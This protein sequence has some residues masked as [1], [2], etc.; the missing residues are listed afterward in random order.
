MRGD[1]LFLRIMIFLIY[2]TDRPLQ[3]AVSLGSSDFRSVHDLVRRQD[4]AT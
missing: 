1:P 2:A 4:A 3:D